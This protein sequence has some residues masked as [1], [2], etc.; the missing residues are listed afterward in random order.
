LLNFLV[1]GAI[2][3]ADYATDPEMSK[4]TIYLYHHTKEEILSGL[5]VLWIM[6]ALSLLM[7]ILDANLVFFHIFLIRKGLTTF[8]YL[9]LVEER[10]ENKR[11]ME[12]ATQAMKGQKK[13]YLDFVLCLGK[14]KKRANKSSFQMNEKEKQ[15]IKKAT[16]KEEEPDQE[17]LPDAKSEEHKDN[18][19]IISN[20]ETETHHNNNHGDIL[21]T[22]ENMLL[23][24]KNDVRINIK[25]FGFVDKEREEAHPN[26][27]HGCLTTDRESS[28]KLGK[29]LEISKHDG[30]HELQY[31]IRQVK[32]SNLHTREVS[33]TNIIE[34]KKKLM[35]NLDGIH[36]GNSGTLA[37]SAQ[38]THNQTNLESPAENEGAENAKLT[39]KIQLINGKGK[40]KFILEGLEPM[41][42]VQKTH[43]QNLQTRGSPGKSITIRER[44]NEEYRELDI[45]IL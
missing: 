26:D 28:E 13:T 27:G 23:S 38:S 40:S 43:V 30:V 25:G 21:R 5:I 44:A 24:T 15:K 12:I 33:Q 35:L 8:Q 41:N 1:F 42:K 4:H 31:E 32:K 16:A 22:E 3:T 19:G 10:K 6:M 37:S 45:E 9:T 20:Y 29:S 17:Q 36:H 7:F 14:G 34:K 11:E 39:E 2:V 18:I